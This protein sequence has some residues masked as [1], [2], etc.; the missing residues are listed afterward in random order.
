MRFGWQT[1]EETAGR[2]GRVSIGVAGVCPR[3]GKVAERR[4][5]LCSAVGVQQANKKESTIEPDSKAPWAETNV[6]KKINGEC[7]I[8]LEIVSWEITD[9]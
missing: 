7:F 1:E 4:E 2:F 5:G 8:P 3:Y 6:S 9:V